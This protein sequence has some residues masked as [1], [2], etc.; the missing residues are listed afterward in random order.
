MTASGGHGVPGQPL[1]NRPRRAESL[2]T[3]SLQ[4]M[5]E[6]AGSELQAAGV[7]EPLGIALADA[8]YWRN[9]AI[10]A[11]LGPASGSSSHPTS[12]QRIPARPARRAL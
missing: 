3:A 7:C 4:P 6:L 5:I 1:R 10:D 8:G 11:L 12:P 9:D 2:D